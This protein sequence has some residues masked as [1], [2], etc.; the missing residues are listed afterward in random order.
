MRILLDTHTFLWFF[1]GSPQLSARARSVIEDPSTE[2]LLSMASL[3]EMAI[4][5]SLGKLSIGA[6]FATFITA[7]VQR[8]GIGLLGVTLDHT[9]HI[10]SLPFHHRD[11]FDRLLVAQA[12]VEQLPIVSA[13]SIL[14][15]YP[16]TRIW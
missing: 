2:P 13:D 4:K 7:Q 10:I 15:S 6:Q 16:V 8:N 9:A 1:A 5:I 3:W 12:V 14:S 11:P